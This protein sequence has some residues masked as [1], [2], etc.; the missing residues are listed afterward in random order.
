[1]GNYSFFSLCRHAFSGHRNW[2]QALPDVAPQN[3]YE[4][5]II[6]GGGHGLATAY[7]LAKNH[8]I[9]NIAVLEKSWLG[10]GNVA[11]NTTIVRSNYFH[12]ARG[13]L[14]EYSLK[15]WENLSRE[16]N[17]NVMFSPR[18]ILNLA[19]S[20]AQLDDYARLGNA[21]AV[22][23]VE[24]ELL[25]VE[26]IERLVPLLDTR[27]EARFPINGG[28]LQRRAGTA[29]HDAVAWGYARAAASR[30][31]DIVQNCEVTGIRRKGR[32]VTGVT[33]TRGTIKT[34][35]VAV[36]T[37]GASSRI[38]E[39]A[40]I[41]FPLENHLLQACVTEPVKPALN[42]IVTHGLLNFYISQTDKGELVLGGN[43]DGYNTY[44]TFGGLSPLEEAVRACL[45][46]FPT[47]SRLRLMRTWGGVVDMSMDGSPIVSKTPLEGF[48]LNAGWCYGGFKATPAVGTVLAQMIASDITPDLAAPFALNR[49][50]SGHIVA[51]EG[52]GP[53]PWR[54]H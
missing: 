8:A 12:E 11:R 39:M 48:Y 26:Q 2:P 21:M 29:R 7:Y 46:L 17:F 35:K 24:A 53:K 52:K 19:H 34:S 31:V 4:V 43:I 30:G 44:S 6:G 3:Q 49:F 9:T 41:R 37:A 36:C 42:T 18:G 32:H 16:L 20:T 5:V 50:H 27:P 14:T 40:G 25:T 13:K 33:T 22:R 15:L 51:E 28:L 54:Y 45:S 10:N 47:F 1:M 23:G 38:G